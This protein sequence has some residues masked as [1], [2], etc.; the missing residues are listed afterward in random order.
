MCAL[1]LFDFMTCRRRLKNNWRDNTTQAFH[2]LL[3]L[4]HASVPLL[5][6]FCL[7]EQR[8]SRNLLEM[9]DASV[10]AP[11]VLP[12]AL[13]PSVRPV[14]RAVGPPGPA[15]CGAAAKAPRYLRRARKGVLEVREN[16]QGPRRR[17]ISARHRCV[18]TRKGGDRG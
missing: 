16:L 8:L 15:G 18:P 11:A 14:D 1:Y 5:V 3:T 7:Q 17:E 10:L 12:L 13:P 9:T 6:S 2:R 4:S